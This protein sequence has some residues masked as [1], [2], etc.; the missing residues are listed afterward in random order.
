M[1]GISYS[2]TLNAQHPD[3]GKKNRITFSPVR[4]VDPVNPGIELGYK[5]LHGKRYATQLSAG[6]LQNIIH[7][8]GF[9]VI[10]DGG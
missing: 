9:N 6:L 7:N 1:I 4:L 8:Q 10:K 5:R 2:K 3:P